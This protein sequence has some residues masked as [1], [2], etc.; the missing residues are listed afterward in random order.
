MLVAYRAALYGPN[1]RGRKAVSNSDRRVGEGGQK[2]TDSF[3]HFRSQMDRKPPFL[4][5]VCS[6]FLCRGIK[7]TDYRVCLSSF[8]DS[9]NKHV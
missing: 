9:V 8:Y 4:C 7:G 6:R 2:V 5:A 3:L 1:M